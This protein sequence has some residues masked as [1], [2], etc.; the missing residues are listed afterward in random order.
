MAPD[1]EAE[2]LRAALADTKAE[3]AAMEA[4]LKELEK[5]D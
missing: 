1:Q 2:T 3:L 5:Q 4:R